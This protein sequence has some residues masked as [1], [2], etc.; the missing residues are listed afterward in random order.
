MAISILPFYVGIIGC[1]VLLAIN[2]I[3]VLKAKAAAEIVSE[4]DDKIKKQTFFIKS[5]A[6]EAESV[7]NRVQN[8]NNKK[9]AIKVFEA[10]K[11]SDAMSKEELNDIEGK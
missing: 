7:V 3:A 5:L 8:D 6:V 9:I 4:I 10:I 1:L 11:Y 2:S